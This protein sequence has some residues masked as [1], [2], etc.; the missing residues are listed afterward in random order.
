MGIRKLETIMQETCTQNPDNLL[1]AFGEIFPKNVRF[2]IYPALNDGSN[3]LRT[4]ANLKIP[5]EI[6]FVYDYLLENGNIVDVKTF[7]KSILSIYHKKVIKM[8][9]EGQAGWEAL[10][11]KK[12][13]SE[14]KS[15]NLFGYKD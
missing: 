14:I 7:D 10:V 4:T 3:E 8:I 2:Y 12:V 13:A 1:A 6:H 11:P 5:Q 15:K 9:E